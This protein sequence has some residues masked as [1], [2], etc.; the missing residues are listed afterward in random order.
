MNS[1]VKTIIL[2]LGFVAF[3]G[4]STLAYNLLKENSKPSPILPTPQ[5]KTAESESAQSEDGN[6]SDGSQSEDEDTSESTSESENIEAF[7]FTASDVD[8]NPVQFSTLI[9][10][11]IVLN[12]WASW[13]PPCKDEMPAFNK[14]YEE[15]GEDITFVMVNMVDGQRETVKKGKDFI[16]K[17]EFTFPV[18]YDT[19]QNAAITY[20]V[21]SLPT[22]YFIDK[23]GYI[24]T[25][26]PGGIDEETLRLGISYIDGS[27]DV[28][29]N[30]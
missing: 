15:L 21:T 1:K 23:D 2:L 25:Y 10:K 6:T 22:T 5:S 16:E 26:A 29:A 24:V 18:Y 14:V 28:D 8:G 9:G 19:E 17:N 3:V 27:A 4:F 30:Q 13:C 7:D 12:F 11:P 20:S